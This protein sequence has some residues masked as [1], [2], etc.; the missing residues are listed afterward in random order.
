MHKFAQYTIFISLQHSHEYPTRARTYLTAHLIEQKF[1]TLLNITNILLEHIKIVN[2]SN[3]FSK[4][5][6]SYL[7]LYFLYLIEEF[8]QKT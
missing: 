4:A 6:F 1:T 2:C 7:Y 3:K 5:L 8:M